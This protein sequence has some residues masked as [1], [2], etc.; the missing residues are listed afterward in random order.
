MKDEAIIELYFARAEEAI[1]QTELSYGQYCRSLAYGILRNHEDAE[2]TV[3]DAYLKTWASIPPQ[4]P[5]NLKGFLGR[6]TRQLS[7][8]RLEKNTAAKRGGGT[9][10]LALDELA[11][12]IPGGNG[13]DLADL[14]ALRD[15]LNRFLYSL[16]R[17]QKNVF[18]RR[19]W[20]MQ[21]V[22]EIAKAC[23]M[24][25]S[26]VKSML[27]RSRNQLRKILTEEGFFL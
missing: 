15:V 5:A 4:R 19:Y 6:I 3:N 2:E 25:E 17:E 24:H 18:I 11:E 22:A 12:C 1:R 16:G 26:K 9:Y 13:E 7:L 21:T 23:A 27:H 20:Y 10:A 14:T 8:N